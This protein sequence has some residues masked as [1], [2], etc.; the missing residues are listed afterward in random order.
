MPARFAVI[1]HL[2]TLFFQLIHTPEPS[3]RPETEL[4]YLALV[5][6]RDEDEATS[7]ALETGPSTVEAQAGLA[8]ANPDQINLSSDHNGVGGDGLILSQPPMHS[9]DGEDKNPARLGSPSVLGKRSNDHLEPM[10]IDRPSPAAGTSAEG[11]TTQ[12]SSSEGDFVVVDRDM[13]QQSPIEQTNATEAGRGVEAGLTSQE[14]Q[15]VEMET[16]LPPAEQAQAGSGESMSSTK[17]ASSAPPLPPRPEQKRKSTI[18][19]TNMM[20]GRQNDVSEAMDNVIFQIQVGLSDKKLLP[21]TVQA[22]KEETERRNFVQR[23]FYGTTRQTLEFL[24]QPDERPRIREEPFSYLLVDVA[25]E[26][27]DLYDG[28]DESFTPSVVEVEGKRASRKDVLADLPPILQIQLQVSSSRLLL[29]ARHG[30]REC[31]S[32]H[33]HLSHL[34]HTPPLRAARAIRSSPGAHIQVERVHAIP[35]QTQDG[36]IRRARPQRLQSGSKAR[37][38]GEPEGACTDSKGQACTAAVRPWRA[39]ELFLSFWQS[40]FNRAQSEAIALP[41]NRKI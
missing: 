5:S 2:Q 16:A 40:P 21:L 38:N 9:P 11:G 14:T 19:S 10:D 8:N 36:P 4:A 29:A 1:A 3:V 20:F 28:L 12:G 34:F 6:T 33:S 22:S 24:D 37:G 7:P 35:T 15:S 17:P 30:A 18:V 39:G 25:Q 26:G 32:L 41:F 31:E 23:L 13:E 27:R